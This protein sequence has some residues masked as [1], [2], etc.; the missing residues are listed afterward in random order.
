MWEGQNKKKILDDMIRNA[1]RLTKYAILENA[2][3]TLGNDHFGNYG[4]EK[5]KLVN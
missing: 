4:C 3:I 2:F 5:H 1:P